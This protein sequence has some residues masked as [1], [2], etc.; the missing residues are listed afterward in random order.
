MMSA[1]K[2]VSLNVI[3]KRGAVDAPKKRQNAPE[4]RV[5]WARPLL[6]G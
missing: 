1:K 4:G 6:Q 2:L 5:N 3:A